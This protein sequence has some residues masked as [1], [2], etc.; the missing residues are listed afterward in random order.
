M[1]AAC[2]SIPVVAARRK[3]AWLGVS[4]AVFLIAAIC[5]IYHLGNGPLAGTEGHRAIAAQQMLRNGNYLV[6]RL[7]G[8]IY[9]MKPP[10]PYWLIAANEKLFGPGELVWRLPSAIASA[11][12]AAGIC[13]ITAVWF[14]AWG[15]FA[16]GL[17]FIGIIALWSQ[18]RSADVDAINHLGSVLAALAIIDLGWRR[19]K[20]PLGMTLL[21]ALGFAVSLLSKGPAGLPIILGAIIG[22]AIV[23]RNMRPLRSKAIYLSL[24]LGCL[25]LVIWAWLAYRIIGEALFNSNMSGVSEAEGHFIISSTKYLPL[26]LTLP[27]IVLVYGLPIS[28]LLAVPF[29]RTFRQ[30]FDA[31]KQQ[32]F[33]A[34]LGCVL[35]AFAIQIFSGLDNPRYAYLVLP[36]LCP[37]AG[38]LI[39]GWRHDFWPG[40]ARHE[41]LFWSTVLSILYCIVGAVFLVIAR[42]MHGASIA[43]CVGLGVLILLALWAGATGKVRWCLAIVAGAI[44]LAALSFGI[45]KSTEDF[46]RS[47]AAQSAALAADVPADQPLFTWN[48]LWSQPELFYYAHLNPTVRRLVPSTDLPSPAWLVL[49]ANEWA[50]WKRAPGYKAHLKRVA[51]LHPYKHIA[52]VCRY[53]K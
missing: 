38:A 8:H 25:P 46:A 14:D 10:L 45:Y 37:L 43:L 15:G 40:R 36:I 49:D 26:V 3:N 24:L 5:F 20:F 9:L 39:Y 51:V 22:P 42:R 33:R 13:G 29:I 12:L 18:D 35:V 34:L 6:P 2:D 1:T 41:V 31:D 11:L 53:S 52:Y 50:A 16:A 17:A 7:Y 47:A 44:C 30:S 48:V 4:C 23:N 27:L 28:G 19:K 32:L 21:A